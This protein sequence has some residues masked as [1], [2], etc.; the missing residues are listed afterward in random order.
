MP[1]NGLVFDI[2]RYSI[3]DGPGI[4]TTV[5]FK[6]CP[7]HCWWCHNPEGISPQ[8]E[9][10]YS[11]YKCMRCSTCAKTCPIGAIE[12]TDKPL[13]KRSLCTGCTLCSE[14]CPSGAMKLVGREIDVDDLMKEI[15]KDVIYY[16]NSGGGVTFSG[17]EPLYQHEFLLKALQACKREGIHTVL[18]TSGYAPQRILVSVMNYV[19]LFLYDLKLSDSKRHQ[20]YTGVSNRIIKENLNF[21]TKMRRADDVILRFPAIP[22]IT[23]TDENV[24]GLAEFISTLD[25][26]SEIDILPFHDVSEKYHRLDKVY[27]MTTHTSPSKEKLTSIKEKFEKSIPAFVQ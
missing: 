2:Q 19:D 9:L 25:G 7:L 26:I 12:F 15:K 10:M 13:V 6:G 11:E 3:H 5:F 27:R 24:N 8:K 14:A 23:D 16:D 21:L 22:G 18:D 17:G 4:R 1:D 20:Q